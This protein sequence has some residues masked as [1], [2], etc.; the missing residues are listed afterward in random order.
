V[1]V[2]VVVEV[3]QH[4]PL[5]CDADYPVLPLVEMLGAITARVE[6]AGAVE[7]EV[8]EVGRVHVDQRPS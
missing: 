7:P 6:A 2:F 8:G 1:T 4:I 3:D 5:V